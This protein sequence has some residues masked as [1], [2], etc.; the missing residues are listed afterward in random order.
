MNSTEVVIPFLV[1][2]STNNQKVKSYSISG[3]HNIIAHQ[4]VHPV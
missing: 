1:G 4:A 2:C 3:L